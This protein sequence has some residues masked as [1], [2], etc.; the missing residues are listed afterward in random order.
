MELAGRITFSHLLTVKAHS[1]SENNLN[2]FESGSNRI[3]EEI[4]DKAMVIIIVLCCCIYR[5]ESIFGICV[6]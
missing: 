2:L 4:I 3:S 1:V 6:E 5:G